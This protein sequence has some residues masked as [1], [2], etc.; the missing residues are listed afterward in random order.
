MTGEKIEVAIKKGQEAQERTETI[1]K[2]ETVVIETI[3][4]DAMIATGEIAHVLETEARE[5]IGMIVVDEMIEIKDEIDAIEATLK[6]KDLALRDVTT[7]ETR[8]EIVALTATPV[9]TTE[10]TTIEVMEVTTTVDSVVTVLHLT[11]DMMIV[12][13]IAQTMIPPA[14]TRRRSAGITPTPSQ[15][16]CVQ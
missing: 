12:E 16:R 4:E 11:M 1:E 15:V 10:D 8:E 9:N 6:W 13:E 3:V 5:E 14:S 2:I 7:A